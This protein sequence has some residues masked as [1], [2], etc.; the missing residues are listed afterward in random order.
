MPLLVVAM[1]VAL[2]ISPLLGIAVVRSVIVIDSIAVLAAAILAIAIRRRRIP[3]RYTH[4]V[5]AV[6]CHG[7]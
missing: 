7:C 4:A 1:T 3:L 2:L 5:V 6:A